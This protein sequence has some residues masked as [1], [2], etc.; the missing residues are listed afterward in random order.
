ML[1]GSPT[2]RLSIQGSLLL[3]TSASSGGPGSLGYSP[4]IYIVRA[5]TA[6]CMQRLDGLDRKLTATLALIYIDH[7]SLNR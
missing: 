4:V 1:Q 5:S 7:I 6:Y 2:Q 3:L